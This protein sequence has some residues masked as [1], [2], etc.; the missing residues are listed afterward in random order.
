MRRFS[1]EV[2]PGSKVQLG[3]ANACDRSILPIFYAVLGSM[4][5]FGVAKYA[6]FFLDQPVSSPCA[7]EELGALPELVC[8]MDLRA[9]IRD[10]AKGLGD[11]ALSLDQLYVNSRAAKCVVGLVGL[12]VGGAAATERKMKE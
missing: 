9:R 6:I 2:V 11:K 3:A 7:S 1:A 4:L 8:Q 12:L 5:V 10:K